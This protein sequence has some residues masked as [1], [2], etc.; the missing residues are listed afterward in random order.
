MTEIYRRVPD[1]VKYRIDY[2]L[3]QLYKKHDYTPIMKELGSLCH[4]GYPFAYA[5]NP[6]LMHD[7]VNKHGY[8]DA[9]RVE[10]MN[11]FFNDEQDMQVE[12][13]YDYMLFIEQ[14]VIRSVITC[15]KAV[16]QINEIF[17]GGLP[18]HDIVVNH[19][20]TNHPFLDDGDPHPP[21]DAIE[22]LEYQVNSRRRNVLA[23][24]FNV[25]LDSFPDYDKKEDPPENNYF[26]GDL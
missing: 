14:D 8:K 13:K 24:L 22:E 9:M 5:C 17:G 3:R 7:F 16:V 11:D 26:F 21:L 2:Y 10:R 6:E 4:P 20:G 19:D 15:K 12:H 18:G 23:T 25:S 1:L